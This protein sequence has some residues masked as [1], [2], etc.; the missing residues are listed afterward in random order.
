[1]I[2][3]Q[4]MAEPSPH[5]RRLHRRA[6]GGRSWLPSCK[7]K[8]P[9]ASGRR[10]PDSERLSPNSDGRLPDSERL[11]PNSDGRLPDSEATAASC[12]AALAAWSRLVPAGIDRTILPGD[13]YSLLRRPGGERTRLG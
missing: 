1:M 10:L 8:R 12:A 6:S 5:G 11:F 2:D 13:H 4:R 7:G 9:G 3:D